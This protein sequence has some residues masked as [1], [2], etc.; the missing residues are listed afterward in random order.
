[1]PITRN[2]VVRI[3]LRMTPL[4]FLFC[5]PHLQSCGERLIKGWGIVVVEA[6]IICVAVLSCCIPAIG[7]LDRR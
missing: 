5:L 3:S 4:L 1:M 6:K 2:R 7:A